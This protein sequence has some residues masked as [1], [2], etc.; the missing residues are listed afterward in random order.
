MPPLSTHPVLTTFPP[1]SH[2]HQADLSAHL[3]KNKNR[4]INPA[5][6][7]AKLVVE[8]DFARQT[9]NAELLASVEL[10]LAEL[11]KLAKAESEEQARTRKLNERN[12][13]QNAAEVKKAE[14]IAQDHRRRQA[15][16]L[17]RGD[18]GVKIDPSARVKT[19]TRLTYDS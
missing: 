9:G 18:A 14:G 11:E 6:S 8:R 17:A 2:L 15:A 19:L 13:Q 10:K 3:A 4:A 1:Q 12:R 7:K 16:A 5:A